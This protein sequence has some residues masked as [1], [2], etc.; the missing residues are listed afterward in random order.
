MSDINLQDKVALITGGTSGIG[1]AT[2][3]ALAKSGAAVVIGGRREAEGRSVVDTITAEGGR[4][5]FVKT[6]V[7]D[8]AQVQALVGAAQTEYGGLDI[9]FNNA[10]IEGAALAP[11]VDETEENVRRVMEVNFFGVWNALKAEIPAM[12]AR[13]GGSIINT[14]STAGLRGFAAFSSYA[15]S[16]FAVE[17]LTRSVAQEVGA[18]GIRVNTVAPGPIATDL[19]DRAT[20]GDPAG[21]VQMIPMGRIGTAKEVAQL[22]RFLASDQ[23]SYINGSTLRADGGMLG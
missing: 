13:G 23:A 11:L 15:A 4:A 12:L 16:K 9:A 1:R 17:G 22:V 14:T 6:D 21:F 8:V 18:S 20:G 7:T 10:G 5:T 19:L 2:A 3:F